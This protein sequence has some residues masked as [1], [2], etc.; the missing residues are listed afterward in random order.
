MQTTIA[1]NLCSLLEKRAIDLGVN[2]RSGKQVKGVLLDNGIKTD[3]LRKDTVSKIKNE[4]DNLEV[5]ELL[6]S[7]EIVCKTSLKKFD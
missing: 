3:N 6:E 2:L 4:T 5:K 1:L 7:K